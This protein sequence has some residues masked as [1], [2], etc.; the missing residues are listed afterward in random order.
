MNRIAYIAANYFFIVFLVF[1]LA[2]N[3]IQAQ[4]VLKSPHNT[5][6]IDKALE[7]FDDNG[8]SDEHN[9]E[10]DEALSGFDGEWGEYE[11]TESIDTVQESYF[12]DL[13]GSSGLGVSYNFTHD[14][15][16]STQADYRCLSRLRTKLNL[17]LKLRFSDAWSALISGKGFYDFAYIIKGRGEF[18]EKTLNL[19]ERELELGETYFQGSLL[20]NL[21][22]KI[23]RQIAVWG[24]SDNIRVVDVINP[25]DNRE[26][27][28][29]DIEDLRL[30][31]TMTRVDYY[32]DKW[33][34]SALSVHEMRLNKNP[35]YGSD[36]YS[37]PV[38]LKEKAPANIIDNT[39]YALAV[40]G[41][42]TGWDISFYL[43]RF[44]DDKPNLQ[45]EL[46]GMELHHSRL[47]MAGLSVNVVKGNL[48][49]KIES[50]Y[51]YGMKYYALPDK[52]ASRFD[53]LAGLEYSGFSDTVISL[54]AVNRHL[55]DY[56]SRMQEMPDSTQE[57]DFQTVLRCNK[58]LMNDTLHLT[59]L[60]SIIGITDDGGGFERYSIE[61]DVIDAFSILA[62]II[63]YR[64]GDRIL[65][66]NIND[67][68]RFFFEAK[69]S[70]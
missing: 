13:T 38:D 1:I 10:I 42:F 43:A 23:G 36:F 51:F 28:V 37:M 54:E 45:G 61:Y 65:F 50:A 70:F 52:R 66:R 9:E 19:Y 30:P 18:T 53:L 21:D 8:L 67:K 35:V 41:I 39:E 14:P 34:L 2:R 17:E 33:N 15:P 60:A 48:L 46:S 63:F 69:Y 57:D 56:E 27:G 49:F 20:S 64:S 26:P 4:E 47:T 40:N 12:Y 68:D 44:Y 5:I 11:T 3:L 6:E 62:G 16:D 32:Y 24:R 59:I 25:M 55:F 29:V 58:D 22:V 31:V 7:G